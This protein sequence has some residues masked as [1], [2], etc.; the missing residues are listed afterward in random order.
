VSSHGD[1]GNGAGGQAAR[2]AV[3]PVLE[4]Y[5]DVTPAGTVDFLRRLSERVRGRQ[6]LHVSATRAGGGVAEILHRLVPLLEDV[7]VRASWDT[8]PEDPN[9]AAAAKVLHNTLQGSDEKLGEEVLDAFREGTRRAAR[10]LVPHAELVFAHDPAAAG[11]VDVRPPD[12]TWVWRCHADVSQPQ[13]R[14]WSFLRQFIVKY[15]AAIYSLPRFAQRLPIPQF[16]VYPSIDPL[17]DKN[18]ELA[19]EEVAR[20]V[21]RLGVP[22]DKPILL[23][24]SR[25]NR[26]KD[27]LGV[28]EAYQIVKKR[29]DCRLV[30]VGGGDSDDPEGEMLEAEVNEAAARDPDIHVLE[31]PPDA[32]LEVNA[33]QRAATV[34]LQKSTREGFGLTVAEAMWKGKPVVGGF[35]GGITKQIVYDVTGYAVNSVEGA[36]F[37]VRQLLADEKLRDTIGRDAREFVRHNFLIT[38]HLGDILALMALLLRS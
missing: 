18:R 3:A 12:G 13:R 9:F 8:L 32:R 34:V 23:Q 38:R 14:A 17:S 5:R 4:E 10:E 15:D 29:D 20:I 7:G 19:A 16:L 22:Q 28:I 30:L 37:R 2:V 1:S 21:T 25:F 24:V 27:P 31:L 33:L 6:I 11:L 35:T 26:F 36:A